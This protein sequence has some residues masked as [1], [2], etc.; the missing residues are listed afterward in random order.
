MSRRNFEILKILGVLVSLAFPIDAVAQSDGASA[1]EPLPC[2]TNIGANGELFKG[3]FSFVSAPAGVHTVEVSDGNIFVDPLQT[4]GTSILIFPLEGA[5][6][7][8]AEVRFFDQNDAEIYSC[9]VTPEVY[10]FD[11][12]GVESITLGVCPDL[13]RPQ[14]MAPRQ[15]NL[16][17]SN[18]DVSNL[19]VNSPQ[20]A[21]GSP[22]G[23]G[24]IFVLTKQVGIMQFGIYEG[25][26]F[27]ENQRHTPRDERR[28]A[29]MGLCPVQIVAADDPLAAPDP[30]ICL[31]ENG[32]AAQVTVGQSVTIQYP[33]DPSVELDMV[34]KGADSRHIDIEIDGD[35]RT[36]DV[37]VQV[38]GKHEFLF[39]S[40]TG[41]QDEIC[42]LVVDP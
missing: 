5:Q 3:F 8:S 34:G 25:R 13:M 37:V 7:G 26:D 21:D 33:L 29:L 24:G 18:R 22:M 38:A 23:F 2:V 14:P 27:L 19:L 9:T 40:E 31:T 16:F 42:M 11:R 15:I 30:Q 17:N 1:Q 41:D 35:R 32:E 4:F 28:Y 39:R 36:V 6:D 20:I 12:D 10:D